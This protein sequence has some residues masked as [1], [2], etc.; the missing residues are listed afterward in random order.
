M[1]KNN[2]IC[3]TDI[4]PSKCI[5]NSYTYFQLY[6]K[7]SLML[8]LLESLTFWKQKSDEQFNND[9][10]RMPHEHGFYYCC[11]FKIGGETSNHFNWLEL[12]FCCTCL[13]TEF[14]L[15]VLMLVIITLVFRQQ[16][17][18]QYCINYSHQLLKANALANFSKFFLLHIMLWRDNTTEFGATLH[19]SFVT[20]HHLCALVFVYMVV[21]HCRA[22]KATLIVLPIYAIKEFIM[23]NLI[24]H[25]DLPIRV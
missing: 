23:Q 6:W 15:L 10:R 8:L 17:N 11:A 12:Y 9:I 4:L 2:T 14:V 22:L 7:L 25:F 5:T 19:R 16:F 13:I 20:A 3:F 24:L 18:Y 1:R 21:S